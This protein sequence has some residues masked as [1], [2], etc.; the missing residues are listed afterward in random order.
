M[1]YCIV[2]SVDKKYFGNK[3]KQIMDKEYLA[4][5]NTVYE[6]GEVA[7]IIA[8]EFVKDPEEGEFFFC[9]N[10]PDDGTQVD[11]T[12]YKLINIRKGGVK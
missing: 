1:T 12:L 5:L 4:M 10:K 7:E 9:N 11:Y 3:R 2:I 8:A 6:D